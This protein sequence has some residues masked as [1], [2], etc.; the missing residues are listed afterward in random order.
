MDR[1]IRPEIGDVFESVVEAI[2]AKGDGITRINNFV[3]FVPN[4]ER[5]DKVRVK[6]DKLCS[7]VGFGEVTT[8]DINTINHI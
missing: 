8:K 6:I 5:G 2:G 1:G 7:K 4:V 3:I